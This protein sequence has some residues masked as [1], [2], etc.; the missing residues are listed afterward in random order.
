MFLRKL[1]G[2]SGRLGVF[3]VSLLA[4]AL[5]PSS[6]FAGAVITPVPTF[7]YPS[8]ILNEP[9]AASVT[10]F[11]SSTGAD[12]A[13]GVTIEGSNL[14][15]FPSC[16]TSVISSNDC[17]PAEA[18]VFTAS[19]TAT[20]GDGHCPAG[21]WTISEPVP[22]RWRFTPPGPIGLQPF[23]HCTIN[24][25]ATAVK[26]PQFDAA[27]A[28]PG[29]QTNQVAAIDA[30][31]PVSGLSVRNSGTGVT[32]VLAPGSD[33]EAGKNAAKLRVS[34]G[35]KPLAKASVTGS[36]V[37]RVVFSV[38]GKKVDSVGKA[39]FKTQIVTKHYSKGRHKLTAQVSFSTASNTLAESLRGGFL[40]CA[41]KRVNFTG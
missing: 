5:F 6:A 1:Q 18:G 27:L 22:A 14:D 37:Q 2:R 39:P 33:T 25:T 41:V 4:I 40:R 34:E 29:M 10:L 20:G 24:F 12:A 30:F 32:T 28:T 8:V 3:A 15:F 16:P 13:A 38:D 36:G 21:N 26:L 19:P 31:S 11:N 9:F 23:E 35:C 7:P 17:P